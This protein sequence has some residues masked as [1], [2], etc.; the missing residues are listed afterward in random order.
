MRVVTSPIRSFVR[1]LI[2]ETESSALT[3][4]RHIKRHRI[5][6]AVRSRSCTKRVSLRG[7]PLPRRTFTAW[8]DDGSFPLAIIQ[9]RSWDFDPSQ[10]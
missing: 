7:V 2:G 4:I 1:A 8:L 5:T 10:V 9:R 3:T 6:L